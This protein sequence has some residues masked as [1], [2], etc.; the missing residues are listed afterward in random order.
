[1]DVKNTIL[2][3]QHWELIDALRNFYRDYQKIPPMR[4]FIKY[5]D[6]QLGAE[7]ANS[8]YIYKLFPQNPLATIAKIAGL[9]KPPHCL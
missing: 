7:K 6:G 4:V 2:T 9:P 8:L 3:E 1:M 5:I